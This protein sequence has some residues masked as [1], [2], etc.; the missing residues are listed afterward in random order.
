M[1]L[2]ATPVRLAGMEPHDEISQPASHEGPASDTSPA[3]PNASHAIQSANTI[4]AAVFGIQDGIVS[5]LGIVM[6]VAGAQLA[7]EAI[8][9]AGIAGLASGAMSMAAGEYV[10][11]QTQRELLALGTVLSDDENVNPL[12]AAAANGGLFIGGG[13]VPLMPFLL[14]TGLAAIS[15]SILLSILALYVT[16]AVLTRLTKRS[17]VKSGMR[18]L[19]IG[20]GAG[21]IGYLVGTVF[22]TLFGV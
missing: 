3:G 16:G 14:G 12:K 9:I 13:F 19:I 21:V 2:S 22:G 8:V 4:R 18:M 20:G 15:A 7:G 10:S 17:P 6:G 11:V 1:N 5:T